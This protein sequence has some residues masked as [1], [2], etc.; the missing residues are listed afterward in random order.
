MIGY[1]YHI[2]NIRTNQRYIGQTIDIDRREKEHFYKLKNNIHPNLK[3]QKA[4][5]KYGEDSFIFEFNK[6]NLNNNEELNILEKCFI[7]QYNSYNDGYNLTL[8]GDGGNTRGKLTYE[9]YCFIYLGCQWKGYTE[10]IGKYLNIDSSSVSS[11]LREKSY[12]WYKEK[13][14]NETEEI[15]QLYI[16]KFKKTFGINRKPDEKRI[17]S[18]LTEDEYYYCFCIAS[19]YS[20]G[21]E[22]ALANYFN[23]HKSFLSNSIKRTK[24][25][26]AYNAFQRFLKLS[27][28]EIQQLGIKYF[29]IWEIQSYSKIKLSIINNH[30]GGTEKWVKLRERP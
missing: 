25:G 18:H 8:G 23:K 28:E 12:L 27:N 1:I 20:R 2:I 10:K 26:K 29:K 19:T 14:D 4:W 21:I 6:Y 11:I 15:K 3:L 13:A 7:Q 9:E 5:N 30:G 16:E 22:Q 17:T 24:A